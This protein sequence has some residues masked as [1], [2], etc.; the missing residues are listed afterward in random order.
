M[1]EDV[2]IKKITRGSIVMTVG[3][4]Q[5]TIQ[6]EAYERGYGSPD[7]VAY[8]SSLKTWDPPHDQTPLDEQT[9]QKI[10][11]GLKEKI[12]ERQMTIE[13]EA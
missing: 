9:R 8:L 12:A 3:N 6:G 2:S 4:R 13:F 5:I 1:S 10:V 7:F 11:K